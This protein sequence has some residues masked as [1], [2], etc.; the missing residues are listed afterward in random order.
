MARRHASLTALLILLVVPSQSALAAIEATPFTGA[1]IPAN[2]LILQ[3]SS[4][5]LRMQTHTVYGLSLGTSLSRR[6]GVEA[7]LGAGTGKLEFVGGTALALGSTAFIADLRGRMRL[8]GSDQTQLGLVLGVGYT[9]FKLGLLDLANEIDQGDYIGRLTGVAGVDLR[10]D[11]G[12]RLHLK[13][14]MVDRIHAQGLSIEG[15]T[16]IDGVSEKTQNDIV[17]TVGLTFSL[18]Q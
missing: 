2:S 10:G 8:L 14:V 7:V 16:G 12:D 5:Y 15:L 4:A 13:F 6:I 17:A 18:T 3:G 11:L 9:D 1:M